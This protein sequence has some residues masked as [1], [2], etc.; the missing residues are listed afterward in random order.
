MKHYRTP[1][2]PTGTAIAALLVFASTPLF[3][4]TIDAAA[5]P[6]VPTVDTPAP[7][8][9]P[10][11]IPTPVSAASTAPAPTLQLPPETQPQSQTSATPP[12]ARQVAAP[13]SAPKKA[14]APKTDVPAPAPVAVQDVPPVFQPPIPSNDIVKPQISQSVPAPAASAPVEQARVPSS[15]FQNGGLLLGLA[16]IGGG[17]AT[18]WLLARR[19]R[20]DEVDDVKGLGAPTYEPGFATSLMPPESAMPTQAR[21]NFAP[22]ATASMSSEAQER[23][24]LVAQAPSPDNPFLTRKNRLR[25]A[26]F[27]MKHTNLG[28]AEAANIAPQP[29]SKPLPARPAGQQVY[30]F[31]KTSSMNGYSLSPKTA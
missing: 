24:A 23:E 10:V 1:A 18:L 22:P 15:Y 13:S 21:P 20:E 14:A 2:R 29:H 30:S 25:R 6:V 9:P 12:A 28:Q 27:I 16:L 7:A 19:R 5:P 31:S 26:S 11:V 4:Q 17:G 8:Q 3:A